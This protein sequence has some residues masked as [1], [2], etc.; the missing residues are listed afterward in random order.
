MAL[1]Q[2]FSRIRPSIVAF[3][4]RLVRSMSDVPPI[5]PPLIGTGFVVDERGI[6]CTNRHV[7]DELQRLP[8]TCP[9][10]VVFPEVDPK[11]GQPLLFRQVLS[12]NVLQ[13]FSSSGT[14]YGELVP[15]IAF[16]QID[17]SG[18]PALQFE[19]RPNILAMGETIATAGFAMGTDPLVVYS[20]V[21]QLTPFLRRGIIS[22]VYPYPCPFPH[23]FTIDI[24]TQGGESGSPVFSEN[25]PDVL[26]MI[27]AGFDRTNITI[28][29]PGAILEE[30]KIEA[31]K[32][33]RSMDF[34]QVPSVRQLL[35]ESAKHED[36]SWSTWSS[37]AQNR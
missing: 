25:S 16:L 3:G 10:A 2:L 5:F 36:L 33:T 32:S 4:S 26:G 29:I 24:M 11:Y 8:P 20:K 1:T 30:A 22:S 17:V 18:L 9:M 34:S 12:Y 6:V 15:D 14:F 23:G 31:M 35:E 13:Q 28:C 37:R 21:T 19:K 27:H 7:A